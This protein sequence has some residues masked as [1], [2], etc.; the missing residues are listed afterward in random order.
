[1]A[2]QFDCLNA[3]ASKLGI[4]R[5]GKVLSGEDLNILVGAANMFI[6]SLGAERQMSWTVKPYVY[7]LVAG[8]RIYPIGPTAPAPFTQP[9]PTE[10]QSW[11]VIFPGGG[12]PLEWT[13]RKV[14]TADDYNAG[15]MLKQLP[16]AFPTDLYYDY[17][18]DS[19]SPNGNI[20]VYPVTNAGGYQLTLY[21][22]QTIQLFDPNNLRPNIFGNLPNGTAG[23]SYPPAYYQM[24][25]YN[26]A[27]IAAP[28][29][30]R[31]VPPEVAAIALRTLNKLKSKNVYVPTLRIS[32]GGRGVYD[33]YSDEALPMNRR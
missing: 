4:K 21:I 1:M 20:F 6:D 11:G 29:F 8:Q 32:I 12:T 16:N 14:L 9:R 2:S 22:P 13:R 28:D 31:S 25:V 18:G 24:L 15:V 23:G 27:V 30:G 17:A 26:I 33:P 3:A 7:P 5:Q 19:D 10:I